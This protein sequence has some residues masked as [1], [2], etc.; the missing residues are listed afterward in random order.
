MELISDFENANL[1]MLKFVNTSYSHHISKK[2]IKI[3]ETQK[4]K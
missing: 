1:N 2:S 4:L 3:I